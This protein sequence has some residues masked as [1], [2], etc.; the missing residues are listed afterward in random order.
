M[1]YACVIHGH[2]HVRRLAYT[3]GSERCVQKVFIFYFVFLLLNFIHDRLD[4]PRVFRNSPEADFHFVLG[5]LIT[6]AS[7]GLGDLI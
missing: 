6:V 5:L 2:V 3:G 7:C 4:G 1:G